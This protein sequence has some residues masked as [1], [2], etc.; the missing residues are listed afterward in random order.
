LHSFLV[1]QAYG[2]VQDDEICNPQHLDINGEGCLFIV[3]NG[4]T[5]G[6]TVGHANGLESFTHTYP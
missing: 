4:L 1:L 6:T 2:V 3:K 5:T